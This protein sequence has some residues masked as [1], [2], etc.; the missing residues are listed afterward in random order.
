VIAAGDTV[1]ITTYAA[2]LVGN[3]AREP[4]YPAGF[5][6]AYRANISS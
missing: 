1:P 5:V 3:L 2:Q 6:A 4:G